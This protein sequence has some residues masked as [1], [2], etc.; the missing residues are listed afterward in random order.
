MRVKLTSLQNKK[1]L[2]I[3]QSEVYKMIHTPEA[4]RPRNVVFP[5]DPNFKFENKNIFSAK[6][7]SMK[8][9]V[10]RPW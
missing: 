5:G 8:R 9:D 3:Q 1:A 10:K 6:Y 7:A 2:D 4:D